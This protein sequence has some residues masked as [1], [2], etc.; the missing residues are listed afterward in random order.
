MGYTY[1]DLLKF[2]SSYGVPPEQSAKVFGVDLPPPPA[3]DAPIAPQ[4]PAAFS[5]SEMGSGPGN[6]VIQARW[7]ALHPGGDFDTQ[8]NEADGVNY[9]STDAEWAQEKARAQG[10]D[11][12]IAP[13][14]PMDL[15]GTQAPRHPGMLR[16]PGLL[17]GN[18][19]VQMPE[20]QI[21]GED[22]ADQAAAA[23]LSMN[24]G[25]VLPPWE[26]NRAATLDENVKTGVTDPKSPVVT[27]EP[28]AP[29]ATTET[30][31]P[32]VANGRELADSMGGQIQA[33]PAIRLSPE[34]RMEMARNALYDPKLMANVRRAEE[35]VTD[36]TMQA[37]GVEGANYANLSSFYGDVARAT[38]DFHRE[39]AADQAR[40]AR[41]AEDDRAEVEQKAKR[42]MESAK[43]SDTAK[44]GQIISYVLGA[45][46]DAAGVRAGGKS[47]DFVNQ[48]I[49]RDD[50][51]TERKYNQAL[52]V[53]E[54]LKVDAATKDKMR[55]QALIDR[56]ANFS[57]SRGAVIDQLNALQNANAANYTQAQAGVIAKEAE[58]LAAEKDMKVD[59]TLR[60]AASMI[61]SSFG[62]PGSRVA[63]VDDDE[64]VQ[65]GTAPDGTPLYFKARGKGTGAELRSNLD[66]ARKADRQLAD[67]EDTLDKQS[68]VSFDLGGLL[69]KGSAWNQKVS[70]A[71]LS[72]KGGGKVTGMNSDKDMSML[73][74]SLGAG[75][76]PVLGFTANQ[77]KARIHAKRMEIQKQIRDAPLLFGSEH[78][79]QAVD[80]NTKAPVY[81]RLGPV[82][83]TNEVSPVQA[84]K[85][86]VK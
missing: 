6:S 41:Q 46:G 56:A 69:G 64:L 67:L 28:K 68:A 50:A 35:G 63:K 29:A 14:S 10:K 8:F 61:P 78:Y 57:A 32:E 65:N 19:V 86:Q 27:G 5:P 79:A 9:D 38:G 62:G 74:E 44:I 70:S 42:T 11:A 15:G 73:A 72:I 59:T 80:P 58:R 30:E 55:R 1:D 31:S 43:P 39:L 48:L 36:A 20:V 83:N 7:Q 75:E 45:F 22:A 49:A 52:K 25:Q 17:A 2:Q 85:P 33:A 76:R 47:T 60:Q 23:A 21:Q 3:V 4:G 34:Q 77:M 82:R 54:N 71:V 81:I 40:A 26:R 84:K 66:N 37:K 12:A 18:N 13:A 51:A 24:G 16:N 53:V